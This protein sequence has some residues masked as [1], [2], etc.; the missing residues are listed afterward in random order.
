MGGRRRRHGEDSIYF[1]HEGSPCKDPAYHRRCRGRWRGAVSLGHGPDGTRIRR[2]VSGR[3]RQDVANALKQLHGELDRGL[4]TSASYSVRQAVSD[5]LDNGLP[6]RSDRTRSAYREATEPL[7]ALIGS[8]ALRELTARDVRAALEALSAKSSTRYLQIARASLVRAIRHAE[9]HDLVGRNVAALVDTP[10]GQ[11]GR[12]SKSL[13]LDQA[14]EVLR[15]ARPSKIFAYVVLSLLTGLRTEEA[16]ALRWTELDL[17]V[18]SVSVL[19]AVRHGGDTKTLRSRRVLKIPRIGVDALERLR[20]E[21]AADR[22]RAGEAWQEHGLV[23]C[24]SIGTPLDAANVRREFRKIAKAAGLDGTWTP[25]ELRHT[26]VSLMSEHGVPVEEI[27][28]L[29]GHH[30]TATTEIVYRH[31]LRPVLQTG[32]DIMDALF[33]TDTLAS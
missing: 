23:F 21:Q 27:A 19:R 1:D 25:R 31:E 29:V 26:F 14:Q 20:L 15:A 33:V 30:Q 22:Y 8:V 11:E 4:R 10:K 16:R 18:G 13:T 7:L 17:E 3:T 28:H 5:W 6:G 32:A 24:T 12:K 2:K 9:A